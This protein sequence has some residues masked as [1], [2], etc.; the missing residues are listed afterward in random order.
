MRVITGVRGLLTS[1]VSLLVCQVAAA[2]HSTSAVFD[3]S[4]T[5]TLVVVISKVDWSN[6]HTYIYVDVA[7]A[8]GKQKTWALET[9][10]PAFLRKAGIT[11]AWL[12]GNGETVTVI[13]NPAWKSPGDLLYLRRVTRPDGSKFQADANL[14]N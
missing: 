12:M 6:P 5:V 3:L 2:H 4:R 11:K 10:P 13:G 8:D 7:D 14:T 9:A 1:V